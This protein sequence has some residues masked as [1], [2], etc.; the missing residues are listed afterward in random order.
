MSAGSCLLY[1]IIGRNARKVF[2]IGINYGI[3]SAG[4]YTSADS[5]STKGRKISTANHAHPPE[6]KRINALSMDEGHGIMIP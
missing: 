2:I 3:M 6:G 5:L 1:G 4:Y